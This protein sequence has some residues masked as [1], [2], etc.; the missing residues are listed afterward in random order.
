[1]NG[2]VI[3]GRRDVGVSLFLFWGGWEPP[4]GW[5]GEGVRTS[6]FIGGGLLPP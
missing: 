6:D 5:G 2:A 1:M 4:P 3:E